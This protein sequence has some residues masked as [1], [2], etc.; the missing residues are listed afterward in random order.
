MNKIA[1]ESLNYYTAPLGIYSYPRHHYYF[2]I[3][4]GGIPK[5]SFY[6][7]YDC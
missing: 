7:H 4:C 2:V 5:D 3:G 6:H 1:T